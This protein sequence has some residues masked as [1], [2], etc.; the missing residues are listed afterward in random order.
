[1][2]TRVKPEPGGVL[3]LSVAYHNSETLSFQGIKGTL[4]YQPIDGLYLPSIE[5][6]E[7]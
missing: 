7:S 2:G 1:M 4:T 6:N 3:R 5:I